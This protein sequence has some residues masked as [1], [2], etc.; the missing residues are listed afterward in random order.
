MYIHKYAIV[1]YFMDILPIG[2]ISMNVQFVN[3]KTAKTC[4]KSIPYSDIEVN[5]FLENIREISTSIIEKNRRK[6]KKKRIRR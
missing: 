3:A 2:N 5:D 4:E 1:R 6:S